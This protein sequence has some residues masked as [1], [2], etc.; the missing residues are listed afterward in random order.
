MIGIRL[1]FNLLEPPM[2]GF[3]LGLIAAAS[4]AWRPHPGQPNGPLF[5]LL[6][7]PPPGERGAPSAELFI[8]APAVAPESGKNSISLGAGFNN[9]PMALSVH[10]H[11]EME[12]KSHEL[13][14]SPLFFSPRAPGFLNVKVQIKKKG[15][16]S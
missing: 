2:N 1:T 13:A 15:Q 5:D 3:A 7:T 11:L 9:P 14:I 8:Q 4:L 6:A 12:G 16:E 10:F